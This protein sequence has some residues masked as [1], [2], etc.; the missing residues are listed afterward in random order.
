MD[1]DIKQYW[2]KVYEDKGP[3]QVSWYKDDLA[4]SL[5]IVASLNISI[6]AKIIDVGGGASVFVDRLLDKGFHHLTVLDISA[7]ALEYAK[8]RLKDL[9]TGVSWIE[10]DVTQFTPAHQYD[11][12][13]DWAVFHFLRSPLDQKR[14]VDVL[15][16]SLSPQGHIIIAAFAPDG[17]LKC[18]GLDV[19]RYDSF[20]LEGVMGKQ[21]RLLR[22]LQETHTTPWNSQQRFNYFVLKN[23]G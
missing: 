9:S 23:N 12:W 11:V 16:R 17:P 20:K 21:F 5:D 22:T 2:E 1:V 8:I 4:L 7:K 3:E 19:E 18:S 13:H 10:S 6:D 14:Y 15:K